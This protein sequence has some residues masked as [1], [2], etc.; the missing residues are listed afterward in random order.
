M[1]SII[2]IWKFAKA[3]IPS[4]IFNFKYLPFAQARKLPIIVFRGKVFRN[5]PGRFV[6]NAPVHFNMIQLGDRLV[7]VYPDTGVVLENKGVIEFRGRIAIGNDSFISVGES[8][9][10][11]LGNG[12][13]AT[14]SL[15][16]ICYH[17]IEFEKDV[18]VGWN[19]MIVD[20]DFHSVTTEN[21]KSKRFG[22]IFVG[23]DT[24]IG[25]SCKIYKNVTIPHSCIVGAD[26]VIRK[27]PDCQPFSLLTNDTKTVVRREN[28]FRDKNNDTIDYTV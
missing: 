20:T 16:L 25:N 12:F 8:G 10:L 6:I 14:T 7:S 19:N 13:R 1:V 5:N 28:V 21:G 22:P 23:H 3:F 15:K 2:K 18:L 24:W 11:I 26:T 4:L 27:I 9:K 17:Y